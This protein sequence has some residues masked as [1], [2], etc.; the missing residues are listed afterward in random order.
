M[1]I[2]RAIEIAKREWGNIRV[3]LER[4]G[5]IGEFSSKNYARG[6]IPPI[7]N[8]PLLI[9]NIIEMENKMPTY[10]YFTKE[11]AHVYA[12]LASGAGERLG[13]NPRLS[14][15]F[16]SGYSWV[17]T[18]CLDLNIVEKKHVIKQLFFYKLFFPLGGHFGWDFN[19][20]S[21]KSKLNLVYH[22]FISWQDN[23]AVYYQDVVKYKEQ[24]EPL[25]NG[26]A[27]ALGFHGEFLKSQGPSEELPKFM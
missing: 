16:S 1:E 27:L 4:C 6:R 15:T 25:W 20:Q 18:G 24:L 22:K 14:Q 9:R 3:S 21:S 2:L 5:D 11:A 26:L 10:S 12:V 17:R 7:A 8:G 23:P 19:S 13:L